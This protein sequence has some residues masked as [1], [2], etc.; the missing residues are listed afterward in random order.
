MF[1]PPTANFF[2]IDSV[3]ITGVVLKES[4]G[5]NPPGSNPRGFATE[6]NKST[7]IRPIYTDPR[8]RYDFL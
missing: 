8:N 6:R 1:D 5:L 3:Q 7:I 4:G 2:L